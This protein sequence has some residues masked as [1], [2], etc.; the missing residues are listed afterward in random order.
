MKT[1]IDLSTAAFAIVAAVL[2]IKSAHVSIWADGK[3]GPRATNMVISKD[4]RLYDVTGTTKAQLVG[5]IS[6]A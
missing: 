3:P 4:G 5:R 6:G 2:W 1:T